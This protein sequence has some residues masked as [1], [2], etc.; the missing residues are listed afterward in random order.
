M[1]NNFII[2]ES[3]ASTTTKSVTTDLIEAEQV[4]YVIRERIRSAEFI[5]HVFHVTQFEFVN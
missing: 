1:L 5:V 4:S 2:R 3:I